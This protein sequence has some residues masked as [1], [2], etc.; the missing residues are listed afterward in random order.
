[1]KF[2]IIKSV[3]FFTLFI[4]G[5]ISAQAAT[6]TVN[7]LTDTGAGSGG[8]GGTGDLR[9]CITQ[10]NAAVGADT[11]NI[12]LFGT[13]L[14]NSNLPYISDS[15]T[16]NGSNQNLLFIDAQ[17]GANRRGFEIDAPAGVN[18]T[19]RNL[20]I[21]NG[22]ITSGG[23]SGGGISLISGAT[24]NLDF[25]TV[26]NNTALSGGAGISVN[27]S[28]LNITN[29]RLTGNTST[30]TGAGGAAINFFNGTLFMS[31]TTL[32]GNSSS[33][34]GAMSFAFVNSAR[35]ENSTISGN[36]G[37]RGGGI[38]NAASTLRMSNVTIGGN[39]ASD[40]GGG[41]VNASNNA[42]ITL[43]NC[44][45]A[46]N[47]ANSGG[48]FYSFGGTN[49]STTIANTIIADNT[50]NFGADINNN[51]SSSIFFE[52]ANI[53]ETGVFGSGGIGGGGSVSQ[54]DPLFYPLGNYG[55]ATA[56]YNFAPNSPARNAGVNSEALNT[57]SAPLT[58]DQ[59][60]TGF[61]RITGSS[62]DIG[63]FEYLSLVVTKTDDTNDGVCDADCSLREAVAASVS[64]NNVEF[65]TLFDTPQTILLNSLIVIPK[66]LTII[67]TGADKLT[68][69]GNNVTSLFE[70]FSVSTASINFIAMTFANGNGIGGNNNNQGGAVEMHGTSA[71]FDK[72]VFRD[73]SAAQIGGALN[74]FAATCRISN[75]TFFNNSAPQASGFYGGTGTTEI[76]NSTFSGNIETSGGIGTL[77]LRGN[78]VIRNS[79]IAN[80]S[81]FSNIYLSSETVNVSIGNTIVAGGTTNDIYRA[82][83]TVTSGG[84]NLIGKN[85]NAGTTFAE[86]GAP[87]TNL[88]FVGTNASPVNPLLAPLGNYG[89]TT[90]TRALLQNSPAINNGTNCV[91]NNSC[92]P[93]I[94][95]ALTADQRGTPRQIG[96]A[97]D[98]GAFEANIT[99]EPGTLSDGNTLQVYNQQLVASRQTNFAENK[100]SSKAENLAPTNFE[101]VPVAGQ[102]LPP[103][104]TLS[105]SGLLTGLPTA[106][107]T[108]NFTVKASD[109]DGV[110]GVQQYS[111]VVFVPTAANV[112]VSGQVFSANGIGLRSAQVILTASNGISR[113]VSSN[114]FGYFRFDEVEAG[115]TYVIS[116]RSKGY[117][118]TPRVL[119]L[120][121]EITG[122]ILTANE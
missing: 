97:V 100:L 104:V 77:Y 113:T 86:A 48:G 118:F 71:T 37:V 53:V 55:G 19:I 75:S 40:L 116:V 66:S 15:L 34:G 69:S 57:S 101:I 41:L 42:S 106:A 70:N 80:N 81:G 24:L 16:I 7:V 120:N 43:R 82:G 93:S 107:G 21:R 79:T 25:V 32:S 122:L 59:R 76:I 112:S 115:Q 99:I 11:I 31:G 78:V 54:V 6:C 30:A 50:A 62:V 9:Y 68:V 89:G 20:T 58:I 94:I 102:S 67:G 72:V 84:G 105:P 4:F 103:G 5:A 56:T 49:V 114:S 35:I 87:N 91:V 98:I 36:N 10:T 64:G 61:P 1:M 110:A 109:T 45:I 23:F 95:F 92:A 119:S 96:T 74:C 63:A 27:A 3:L 46:G 17:N 14:L 39:T 121:E 117:R 33:N 22:N 28:T 29:S 47:R 44:T 26:A 108:Y 83:G 90:P 13:I 8:A 85:T 65:S 38:Y 73:N 12:G 111:M 52:G 18:V 88:D 2:S 60:G 51:F